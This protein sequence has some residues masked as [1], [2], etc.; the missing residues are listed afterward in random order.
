MSRIVRTDCDVCG[1]EITSLRPARERL[2]AEV[3][4]VLITVSFA[5]PE[6]REAGDEVLPK[7]DVCQECAEGV[8]DAAAAKLSNATKRPALRV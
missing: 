7:P 8:R 2:S 5:A 4:G 1:R 3:E 6:P